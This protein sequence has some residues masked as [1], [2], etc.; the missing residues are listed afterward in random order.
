M[1]DPTLD[2]PPDASPEAPDLL[3]VAAERQRTSDQ[4]ILENMAELFVRDD[5]RLSER[6]RALMESILAKLIHGV[7]MRVRQDLAKRLEGLET[8]PRAL[9]VMLAND[10]VAVARPLLLSSPLLRDP[11]LIEIVKNRSQEHLLSVALRRPLSTTVAEAIVDYGDEQVIE[12]LLKNSDAALSR[13]AFEYLVAESRQ[14]DQFQE[15]LLERADLPTDLAYRMF[16]WVSGALRQ[17]ILKRYDVDPGMLDDMLQESTRSAMADPPAPT[18]RTEATRLTAALA[19]ARALDDRFLIQALRNG[20]ITAVV[21]ALALR[22]G[23]SQEIARR[24][25]FDAGGETLAIA[26]RAIG[27]DRGSFST[28]FLLSRQ[29]RGRGEQPSVLRDILAF[30]DV[31]S[32]AK[33]RGVI[34][35]W[36]ADQEYL[37]AIAAFGDTPSGM[38][39]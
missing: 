39:P 38:Q 34:R 32:E 25:L 2:P 26:C 30:F 11:D 10:D 3:E 18:A 5:H 19:D 20:R 33:A 35:Y 36:R 27:M 7:E 17:V 16:W 24:I 8:A 15:P 4:I 1:T 14:V 9:V 12:Q 37:A 13:R 23:I 29:G 22:C 28:V 31:A 21:A 6:E